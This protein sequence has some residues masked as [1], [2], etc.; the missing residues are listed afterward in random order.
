MGCYQVNKKQE[1]KTSETPNLYLKA[2]FYGNF[3]LEEKTLVK[4]KKDRYNIK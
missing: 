1:N 4:K 3:S 2:T